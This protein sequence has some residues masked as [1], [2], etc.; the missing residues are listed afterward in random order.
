MEKNV[1]DI[2]DVPRYSEA[3]RI[4][5]LVNRER[6]LRGRPGITNNFLLAVREESKKIEKIA[7]EWKQAY[8]ALEEKLTLALEKN[9]MLENERESLIRKLQTAQQENGNLDQLYKGAQLIQELY[10][11]DRDAEE[12]EA[13]F[14][15]LSTD[16]K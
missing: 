11:V 12:L 3:A 7:E 15:A 16:E 2:P 13:A 14:A 10:I 1:L 5:N 9:A 6:N 4:D 8:Y